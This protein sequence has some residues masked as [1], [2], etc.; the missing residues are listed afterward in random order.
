MLP[1]IGSPEMTKRATELEAMW[2]YKIEVQG[3]FAEQPDDSF[4]RCPNCPFVGE[5]SD[6]FDCADFDC[7]P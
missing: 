1:K 2:Q 7:Q 3:V 6:G 5:L 4:Q